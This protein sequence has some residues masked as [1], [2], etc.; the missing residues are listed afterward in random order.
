[1]IDRVNF[2]FPGMS[3]NPNYIDIIITTLI[4]CSDHAFFQQPLI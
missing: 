4:V 2:N 1:M 3:I